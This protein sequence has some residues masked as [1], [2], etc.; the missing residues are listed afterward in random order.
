MKGHGPRTGAAARTPGLVTTPV[1]VFGG[2]RHAGAV[3]V[4]PRSIGTVSSR[5]FS[6]RDFCGLIRLCALDNDTFG[7]RMSDLLTWHLVWGAAYGHSFTALPALCEWIRDRLVEV[8][9]RRQREL[10]D[11]LLLPCEVH[12]VSRLQTDDDPVRLAREV[13]PAVARRMRRDSRYEGPVLRG[14]YLCHRVQTDDDLRDDVR[15]LAWRP[16]M[17]G[18]CSAPSY[19]VHCALRVALGRSSGDGFD[20]RPLLAL[21]HPRVPQAREALAALVARRPTAQQVA[22]WELRRGLSSVEACVD[23]RPVDVGGPGMQADDAA[24]LVAAGRR[25]IDGALTLLE[26][27][28]HRR[29]AADGLTPSLAAARRRALVACLAVDRGVCPAAVVARRYRRA[30]STLSEQ[31]AACRRRPPDALL[32]RIPT[33]RIVEEVLGMEEASG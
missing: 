12:V 6:L 32:L 3:E 31:M 30:R 23:R 8:H 11:F 4:F 21:F 26:T 1:K 2:C 18:L 28:V 24:R 16:V 14:R 13:G 10:V 20:P 15:M 19:H 33:F 25:G 27:W 22:Y 17:A 9:R 5:C 29:M 7:R